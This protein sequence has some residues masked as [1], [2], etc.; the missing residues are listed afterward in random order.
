MN[1][2]HEDDYDG[3]VVKLPNWFIELNNLQPALDEFTKTTF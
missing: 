2:F 1:N 3:V